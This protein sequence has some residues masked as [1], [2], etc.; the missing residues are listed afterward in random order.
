MLDQL[1]LRQRIAIKVQGGN[2]ASVAE[3]VPSVKALNELYYL[4]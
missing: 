1:F 2:V 3:K 4:T